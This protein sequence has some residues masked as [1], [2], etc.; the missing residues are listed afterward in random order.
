MK[1]GGGMPFRRQ[2]YESLPLGCFTDCYPGTRV[3]GSE[4]KL[5]HEQSN[6]G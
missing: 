5:H 3:L 1:K 2:G 6:P 4:F